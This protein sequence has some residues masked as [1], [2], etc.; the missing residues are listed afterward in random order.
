MFRSPRF[1][2]DLNGA[3]RL[4]TDAVLGVTDLV[5][6]SHQAVWTALGVPARVPGRTRGLTGHIYA[7]VRG[8]T[9]LVGHGAALAVDAAVEPRDLENP[10]S[11]APTLR[12][13]LNGVVG[14][15]LSATGNPLATPMSLHVRGRPLVC[16]SSP[17]AEE[18][19]EPFGVPEPFDMPEPFD[20]P[21]ATSRIALLVHGL[22]M[23]ER[24]WDAAAQHEPEG[25]GY[26]EALEALGYTPVRVRYNTGRSIAENGRRLARL[27]SVLYARWPA[28]VNEIAVVA[29]S[30]GGLVIRSALHHADALG[31][32]AALGW[33]PHLR[34]VVCLGTPHH[35]APLERLG[36]WV[37]AMLGLSRFTAPYA[38]IGAVR[39]AGITDLRWGRVAGRAAPIPLPQDIAWYAIAGTLGDSVDEPPAPSPLDPR[40]WVE[41]LVG[42]GLVPVASALGEDSRSDASLDIRASHRQLVTETGHL[43]LLRSPE[44][45]AWLVRWL[46]PTW[47]AVSVR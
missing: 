41:T 6:A 2:S 39:S 46:G 5:E 17:E 21:E 25:S 43:A 29:H 30:M 31:C 33:R 27:L 11:S 7:A 37:D 13:V 14:D 9:H 38:R 28:P 34:R 44:V 4:A 10:R 47:G 42:D 36:G 20:V 24:A 19:P 16:E 3:V 8:T 26:A 23:D 15:Y 22:C 40:S 12:A 1:L 35:G 18:A 32:D 45:T